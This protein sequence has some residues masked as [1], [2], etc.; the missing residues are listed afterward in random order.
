MKRSDI[1]Y[2][3]ETTGINQQG[4]LGQIGMYGHT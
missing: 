4:Y 2:Y 1:N 3:T